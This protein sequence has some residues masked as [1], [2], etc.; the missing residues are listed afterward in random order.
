MCHFKEQ[1]I[2]NEHIFVIAWFAIP[3][4][5][6]ARALLMFQTKIKSSEAEHRRRG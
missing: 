4:F 1:N 2:I 5:L 3:E 6:P